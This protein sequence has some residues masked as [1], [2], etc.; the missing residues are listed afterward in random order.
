MAGVR[1]IIK[2]TNG[3]LKK[4]RPNLICI[5]VKCVLIFFLFKKYQINMYFFG[6]FEHANIKVK[7]VKK[8]ILF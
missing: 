7:K 1:E 4:I 5:F 2:N 8:Y 6:R 3:F